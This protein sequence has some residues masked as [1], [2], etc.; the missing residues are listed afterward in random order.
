MFID[1]VAG[2]EGP[3]HPEGMTCCLMY[4]RLINCRGNDMLFD[5][6]KTDKLQSLDG[7][8]KKRKGL[9]FQPSM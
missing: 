9:V 3:V 8:E 6:Y 2:H 1:V 4:T 5:V 7:E